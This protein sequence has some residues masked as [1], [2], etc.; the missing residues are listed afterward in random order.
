M[1]QKS[2][3][4][5]CIF[6]SFHLILKAQDVNKDSILNAVTNNS[7]SDKAELLI[8]LSTQ[9]LH[10]NPGESAIYSKLALEKATENQEWQIAAQALLNLGHAAILQGNYDS[11]RMHFNQAKE[12]TQKE[13][14]QYEYFQSL[15]GIATVLNKLR[16][17]DSAQM[18][19]L[20]VIKQSEESDF[21]SYTPALWNALAISYDQSGSYDQAIE[22]YMKAVA[23]YREQKDWTTLAIILNNLGSSHLSIDNNITAIKYL[24]EAL[25]VSK[26]IHSET[27]IERSYSNLGIAYQN[28]DSL[29]MAIQCFQKSLD[30]SKSQNLK[31]KIAKNHLNIGQIYTLKKMPDSA[32]YHLQKSLKICVES[33]FD[34]GIFLNKINLGNVNLERGA[35]QKAYIN[36]AY[37]KELLKYFNVPSEESELLEGLYLV[38]KNLGQ[39]DSALYYLEAYA[40]LNDS[41]VKQEQK[42]RISELELKYNTEKKLREIDQLKEDIAIQ[43]SK[44]R[45]FIIALIGA[46]LLAAATFIIY[47]V[48][49]RNKKLKKNLTEKEQQ[50]LQNELALKEKELTL[51]TLQ[52][53]NNFEITESTIKQL[54]SIIPK[55]SNTDK[56]LIYEII[57]NLSDGSQEQAW[58]DFEI[59]FDKLQQD[60]YRVLKEIAPDLTPAEIKICSLLKLNLSTKD[61]ATITFRSNRTIENTRTS[62]R[63]KLN[64]SSETNLTTFL[65]SI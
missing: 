34:F 39:K 35:W 5:V 12:I 18:I 65:L 62:I 37:A 54:K 27:N 2:I 40:A 15:H 22:Y 26:I 41:I 24:K 1:S 57:E 13:E 7:Q 31:M 36:Y 61:I 52:M 49:V 14:I 29:D 58:K 10:E 60:F 64:L 46:I 9:T 50:Q 32:E 28:I 16:K 51:K 30:I 6:I 21:R 25:E 55:L 48:S 33:E 59:H 19:L 53:V 63:K 3:L 38:H 4:V 47:I 45:I 44:S 20:D 8:D 43:K 23:H 42:E 56:N 11:A 17:S